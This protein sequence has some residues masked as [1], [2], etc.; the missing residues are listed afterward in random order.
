MEFPI[1]WDTMNGR[2]KV[3]WIDKNEEE[4]KINGTDKGDKF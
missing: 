2:E 1:N 3:E 4:I